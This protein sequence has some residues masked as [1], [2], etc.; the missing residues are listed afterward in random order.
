MNSINSSMIVSVIIPIYNVEKF[1]RRCLESVIA[2]ECDDFDIECI[3]VDDCSP[4][5]S[6]AIAQ[7]V[8]DKYNGSIIFF[9]LS[10]TNNQ[11]VSVSR[12]NGLAIS[13]GDYVF[14]LDS[15]DYLS[16][17]CLSCLYKEIN[18]YGC[19][20]DMVVG[21]SYNYISGHY[22]VK[23]NVPFL[24]LYHSD[25]MRRF[26]RVELP[27][28]AWNK[29]IRRQF[30]LDNHISFLPHM[31]HED[32]LWSYKL[33]D[34]VSS[35]VLIPEVTYHYEKNVD[36][37]MNSASNLIRRAEGYHI[38]VSNMLN[39][40][41]PDLYVERFFWGI[42]MYMQSDEIIRC[43][44]LFGE[45]VSANIQLR[46]RMVKR[47]LVDGR[48]S[49]SLFLMLTIQ[50]PFRWLIRYG[51]FRHNYHRVRK[52]FWKLALFFDFMH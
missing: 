14:F 20:V 36:S 29:L 37:I 32:E 34:I 31:L 42:Y 25:I 10:N 23:G 11:G 5:K 26:L 27:T 17:N 45:I 33:Y 16:K 47:S 49:I 52:L 46:K 3:L 13:K 44:G 35:I 12:N 30:L 50:P 39:S 18:Q 19:V 38:L 4:D 7:N 15:D 21:N 48:L 41:S 2:Q 43:G 1:I 51:W 28:M 8:I 6:M 22:W 24:L 9:I 40:L